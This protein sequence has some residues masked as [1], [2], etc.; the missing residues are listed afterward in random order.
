M[1]RLLFLLTLAACAP[2]GGDDGGSGGGA[3]GSGGSGGTCSD[4]KSPPNLLNNASFECGAVEP[5]DW[6]ARDGM[7]SLVSTG[8]KHG[9]RAAQLTVP[10]TGS[11]DLTLAHSADVATDLGNRIYCATAWMK[12][13]VPDAKLILRR[14][15]GSAI[16]DFTFSSPIAANQPPGSWVRLP[17]TLILEAPGAGGDR[18]LLLAQSRNGSPGRTLLI[19]DADVWVSSTGRCDEAR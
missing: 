19:D 12:G 18:L 5:G 9:Q 15:T 7:F 13:T 14:V 3:G 6:F 8:A 16:E 10:A 1:P 17:P 11:I 4:A 2:P